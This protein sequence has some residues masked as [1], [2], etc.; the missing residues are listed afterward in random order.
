MT[1]DYK[2]AIKLAKHYK[3][4]GMT[5]VYLN[6]DEAEK[7]WH[8]VTKCEPGGSH[9]L[10]ISTSVRFFAVDPDS[11]LHFD[12]SFDIEPYEANGKGSYE[13]DAKACRN[14]LAK[15]PAKA[16]KQ[17]REYLAECAE[18]V[19][20]KGDEYFKIYQ[21]QQADADTLRKLSG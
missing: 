7:P 10:D 5:R 12:W 19:A 21:R 13:I 20:A 3:A 4:L 8:L 18:K 11:G 6:K 9:R 16:A 1:E 17:F 14:V 2:E 15:L